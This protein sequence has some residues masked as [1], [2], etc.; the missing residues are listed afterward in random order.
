[1]ATSKLSTSTSSGTDEENKINYET[2]LSVEDTDIEIH[3]DTSNWSAVDKK[4]YKT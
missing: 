2:N 1:M 3:T 4:S